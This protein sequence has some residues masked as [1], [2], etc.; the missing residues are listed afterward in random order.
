LERIE[1]LG[2]MG[3]TVKVKDGYAR[4]FLLPQKKALRAN[5][6]NKEIFAAQ[7]ARIEADNAK[8][9]ADAEAQ[10]PKIDGVSVTVIRQASED[11]RL[12][13]SVGPRDVEIALKEKGLDIPRKHI[14]LADSIKNIGAYK[15]VIKLHAEVNASITVNVS[16]TEE[17]AQEAA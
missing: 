16:R 17:S 12:Y 9:K 13:G 3:D 8:L 4:N 15:A 11:G 10:L 1:R 14:Q 7:R 5:A 6:E 2:G